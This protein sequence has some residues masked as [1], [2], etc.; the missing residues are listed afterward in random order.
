[1]NDTVYLD[2]LVKNVLSRRMER[3][4]AHDGDMG[5]RGLGNTVIQGIRGRG[6]AGTKI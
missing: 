6:V 1:M 5:T 3:N 4:P 2:K